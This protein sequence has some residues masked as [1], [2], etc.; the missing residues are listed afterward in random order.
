MFRRLLTYTHVSARVLFML[1]LPCRGS[2]IRPQSSVLLSSRLVLSLL[3]CRY[4]E[5][6]RFEKWS[7][8]VVFGIEA[9]HSLL[10]YSSPH[11][12]V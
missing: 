10:L 11:T 6:H 8:A 9:V 4:E 1:E 5:I 7:S 3:W 12:R 2:I